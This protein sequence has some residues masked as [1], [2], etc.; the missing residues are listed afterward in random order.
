VIPQITVTRREQDGI[1]VACEALFEGQRCTRRGEWV[2]AISVDDDVESWTV[3]SQDVAPVVMDNL[4]AL[5][6]AAEYP[7][8]VLGSPFP[9][10]DDVGPFVA[11]M[12]LS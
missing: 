5:R 12:N 6:E 2:V 9:P 4:H 3:C 10:D 11:E 8:D 1:Q 7:V